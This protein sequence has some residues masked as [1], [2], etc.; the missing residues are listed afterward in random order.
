MTLLMSCTIQE[1]VNG[2]SFSPSGDLL[3]TACDDGQIR[4]WDV[5]SGKFR[6]AIEGH[7]QSAIDVR[8]F[9]HEGQLLLASADDS[10]GRLIVYDVATH[11]VLHEMDNYRVGRR[12]LTASNVATLAWPHPDGVLGVWSYLTGEL[13]AGFQQ[14]FVHA[15]DLSPDG[16]LLAAACTDRKIRIWD[17]N[18]QILQCTLSAHSTLA[19]C[20]KFSPDGALLA[21]GGLD[22]TLMLWSV[23]SLRD[24]EVPILVR[25]FTAHGGAVEVVCVFT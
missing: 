19:Q 3:A 18:S 1:I 17:V 25:R 24:S 7:V 21:T 5:A 2:I 23:P 12:Y 15:L 6:D 16:Q 4:L 22:R 14:G 9:D 10:D 20:L 11:R 8:F 13:V